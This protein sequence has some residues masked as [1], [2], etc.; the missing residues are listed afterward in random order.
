MEALN[1]LKFWK[2]TTFGPVLEVDN[3]VEEEEEEEEDS[4][5]DLELTT[6]DFDHKEKNPDEKATRE[7]ES[8]DLQ[9]EK[10]SVPDKTPS[11]RELCYPKPSISLSPID[12][13]SKRKILPLEPIN[14]KPQSPIALL[15]SAPTFRVFTFKKSKSRGTETTEKTR[16][17]VSFVDN[18]KQLRPEGKLFTVRL[19]VEEAA[20]NVS[21]LTR[22]SSSRRTG[23]AKRQDQT[24]DDTKTEQRFSKDVIQ[25]YLKLVKPLYVKVSKRYSEKTTNPSPAAD[26]FIAS[27]ASSPAMTASMASSKDRP[28]NNFPAGIRTVCKHLGKSKS[29][30]SAVASTAQPPANRRDDSLLQQHDG[31]QSAILHCKRSFN[32]SRDSFSLSRSTSDSSSMKSCS[33]DS[34]RLSNSASETSHDFSARSSIEEGRGVNI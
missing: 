22:E 34:Y 14:P 15:K 17:A 1:F 31:I 11:S 13:I 25:K 3:E 29:S 19:S 27:P 18:R 33:S 5:F 8:L 4:F 32:S 23:T 10:A 6:P 16:E 12:S 2:P 21:R 20:S 7:T 28:G 24:P 26:F 30:S 9:E